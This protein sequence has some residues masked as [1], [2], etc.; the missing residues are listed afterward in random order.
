ME[1]LDFGTKLIEIRKAKGLTQEEVAEMC[2]ITVRTIH[3]IES[4]VVKPRTFTIKIISENLG[5]DFFETSSTGY[6]GSIENQNSK[7]ESKTILWYVKDLFN[8]KTK[9]MKKNSI[10]S[11]STFLI[12]FLCICIFNAT[13]QSNNL[14]KQKSLTILRNED[15]SVKRVE[16]AFTHNLTLDSLVKIKKDLQAIGI[17]INYKK[18]EFDIIN[19]LV[20]IECEV[21]CNDGFSGSFMTD[22]RNQKGDVR[23]GFYRD[24]TPNCKSPFGTGLLDKN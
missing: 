23:I 19:S 15:K 4:G 6:D 24:Y 22:L 12:I 1:K 20:S 5:F 14:K 8:L 3:R 2:K 9:T 17:T 13:A 10:L 21:I 18:M 7:I 11:A 16:A